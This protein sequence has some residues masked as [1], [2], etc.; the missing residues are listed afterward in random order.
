MHNPD[1]DQSPFN[2]VPPVVMLIAGVMCAVE[3][4][5]QA[6]AAGIL[7]GPEAIG[8]RLAAVRSY[9]FLDPVWDWMLSNG[10]FPPEHLLRF[11]TFP[12]IHGTFTHAAFAIV[13]ILA[14]GKVVG[15]VFSPLAFLATFFA[16]SMIGA[17]VFSTLVDT[18]VPLF[19]GYAGA[20]G[21]IGAFTFLLWVNLSAVGANSMRAFTLIAVLM[22]IQLV[23]GLLFGADPTW[24]ADLTGFCAGFG[25]SFLVSPGGWSRV[26]AKLRQR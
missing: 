17:V 24:I 9:A 1:A 7:G 6:G 13:I 16:S 18:D 14:I 20:Y 15:E 21:L 12:F 8:W 10:R 23:Y 4:A 19:G 11:L 22:G 2:P 3:L 5:F 26:V 25:L